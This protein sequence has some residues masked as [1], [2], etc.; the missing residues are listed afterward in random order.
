MYFRANSSDSERIYDWAVAGLTDF[1]L[2]YL[3]LT[4]PRVGAQSVVPEQDPSTRHPLHNARFRDLYSGNL[5]GARGFTPHSAQVAV[6]RKIYDMVALGRWFLSTPDLPTRLRAGRPLNRLIDAHSMA[7]ALP[8]I[9]TIV[10]GRI[11]AAPGS[12]PKIRLIS[13]RSGSPCYG[14]DGHLPKCGRLTRPSW[15]L[16]HVSQ[17][18]ARRSSFA[19]AAAGS[20][21]IQ[22]A[23]SRA[24]CSF[25]GHR[26]GFER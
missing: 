25:R 8:A 26:P 3:M 6:K 12:G 23:V 18:V 17:T 13:A 7:G 1:P 16:F 5:I 24:F 20:G 15:L 19:R 22:S 14:Y 11:S 2:A 9:Q 4:K 21:R 10:I